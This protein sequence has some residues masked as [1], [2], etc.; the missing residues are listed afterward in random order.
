MSKK[1]IIGYFSLPSKTPKEFPRT[2]LVLDK[3]EKVH[4]GEPT[5]PVISNCH[6]VRS[7]ARGDIILTK[8]GKSFMS[9][10]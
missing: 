1:I 4:I 2:F 5:G 9:S 8:R 7:L 3:D 10:K 6:F